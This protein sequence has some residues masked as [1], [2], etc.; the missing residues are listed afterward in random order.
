MTR[1]NIR[2]IQVIAPKSVHNSPAGLRLAQFGPV[3][4]DSQFDNGNDSELFEFEMI[5]TPPGFVDRDPNNPKLHTGGPFYDYDFE[6]IQLLE[7][8]LTH[9]S[10]PSMNNERLEFLGDAVLDIVVSEAVFAQRPE[11]TEGVLSRLRSSLVK[12]T[13]LAEISAELDWGRERKRAAGT[14]EHR[15]LR[16]RWKR[17]SARCIWMPAS[18]KPVVSFTMPMVSV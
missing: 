10:A 6:N 11:A 4:L 12:D 18:T 13:A 2:D 1:A 9:R 3:Y 15:Y 7:Q 14:V 5:F 16:T 8:A 17:S